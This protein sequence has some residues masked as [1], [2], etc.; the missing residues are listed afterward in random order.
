MFANCPVT[1]I[2]DDVPLYVSEIDGDEVIVTEVTEDPPLL[3]VNGIDTCVG[4]NIVG[5]PRDGACGTVAGVTEL[6][7]ELAIE[8]PFALTALI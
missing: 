8:S 7:C 3:I 2:G 4:D 5:V 1:V 6:D